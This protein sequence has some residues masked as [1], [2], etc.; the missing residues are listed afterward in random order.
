MSIQRFD[1][2]RRRSRM[3]I[4]NGTCHISGQFSDAGGD[5]AAQTRETLAK[6]DAL[7]DRAGTTREHLLTAQVWLADLADFDAMNEVWNAW[8]PEG[9]APTRCCCAVQLADPEMRI[10]VVVSA[11]LPD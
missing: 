9:H 8:V 6:I 1:T 11:A 3:V 2:N 10:E 7:L 5:I 4:H